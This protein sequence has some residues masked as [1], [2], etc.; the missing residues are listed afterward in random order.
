MRPCESNRPLRANKAGSTSSSMRHKPSQTVPV[1]RIVGWRRHKK[2]SCSAAMVLAGKR[3]VAHVRAAVP[4]ARMTCGHWC[5]QNSSLVEAATTT[6]AVLE[7]TKG[8]ERVREGNRCG[9]VS[10]VVHPTK[11]C[12]GCVAPLIRP[13]TL[14]SF[15]SGRGSLVGLHSRTHATS[16][17]NAELR[18][19]SCRAPSSSK[20]SRKTVAV[21]AVFAACKCEANSERVNVGQRQSCG[22]KH[23]LT[24][25]HGEEA[26]TKLGEVT[27]CFHG[28]WKRDGPCEGRMS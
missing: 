3:A 5:S 12:R 28:G 7:G 26:L 10:V 14:I 13:K 23:Q 20:D 1:G 16:D 27:D 4:G 22:R 17:N 9:S 8:V 2:V 11:T 15:S 18:R 24:L 25:D 21:R 19:S 6:V